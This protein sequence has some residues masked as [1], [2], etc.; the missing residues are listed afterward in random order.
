MPLNICFTISKR[1]RE[2]RLS[3]EGGWFGQNSVLIRRRKAKDPTSM[4]F[5]CPLCEEMQGYVCIFVVL[6]DGY[7]GIS[8]D[9]IETSRKVRVYMRTLELVTQFPGW[10]PWKSPFGLVL[11]STIVNMGKGSGTVKNLRWH[12]WSPIGYTCFIEHLDAFSFPR[13]QG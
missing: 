12:K 10:D 2:L 9:A 3:W 4:S 5:L 1:L 6:L 11:Y 7:D 13:M 8:G